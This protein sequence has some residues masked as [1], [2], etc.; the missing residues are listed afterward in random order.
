M[1]RGPGIG[2]RIFPG[3]REPATI[4]DIKVF[5]RSR[6]DKTTRVG[7]N[8][9]DEEFSDAL[10]CSKTRKPGAEEPVNP[11]FRGQPEKAASVGGNG[12]DGQVLE[13]FRLAIG[14]EN[15][16]LRRQETSEHD[17]GRPCPNQANACE[18]CRF[19][20]C[21]QGFELPAFQLSARWS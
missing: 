6:P 13:A 3:R 7:D 20:R 17:Q 9:A 5:A 16:L 15:V 18:G 14:A 21:D 2:S 12:I 4:P 1:C 11:V 10:L 8:I 19:G